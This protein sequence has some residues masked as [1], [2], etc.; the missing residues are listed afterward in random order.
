MPALTRRRS[1]DALLWRRARRHGRETE[2]KYAMWKRGKRL[3][4][5]KPNSL[6]SCPCG[7]VFE[8]HRLEDTI[9]PC[10]HHRGSKAWNQPGQFDCGIVP[11]WKRGGLGRMMRAMKKARIPITTEPRQSYEIWVEQDGRRHLFAI[12]GS[13]EDAEEEAREAER[14]YGLKPAR[15]K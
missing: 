15:E 9:V 6:L 1:A 3:P 2:R 13:L 5:Q 12:A 14:E 4:S 7:K 11:S 8:I 10:P